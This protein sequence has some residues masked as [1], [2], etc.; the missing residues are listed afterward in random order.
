MRIVLAVDEADIGRVRAG[1]TVDFTV[2]AF[3]DRRFTGTVG[4]VRL[5]AVITNNV[6]SYPVVVEVDNADEA[7]LPGMTANAEIR[8]ERRTDVITVANA[9]LR[10][11]PAG[12][13]TQQG[14]AER[15]A[16][17]GGGAGAELDRIAASLELDATQQAT[18]AQVQEQR[19]QRRQQAGAGDNGNRLFG[20]QGGGRREAAGSDQALQRNMQQRMI[21]LYAPFRATLRPEQQAKWDAALAA[22]ATQRSGSA[23][24]LVD[25]EPVETRVRLGLSDGTRTE[26]VGGD[27]AA[28]ALAI[29]GE[30]RAAGAP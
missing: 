7:L 26:V 15:A 8:I 13:T 12:A 6:V 30:Q 22:L 16:R 19:A 9:A 1:Q 29:T 3:P 17:A 11:R 2:D 25:G 14:T 10:W 4:Q 24:L 21:V 23:Y 28:G 20:G 18:L 27:V 5:A